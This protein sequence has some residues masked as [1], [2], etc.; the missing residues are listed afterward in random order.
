MEFLDTQHGEDFRILG[1]DFVQANVHHVATD[2]LDHAE[3]AWLRREKNS[4][5]GIGAKVRLRG[6][7]AVAANQEFLDELS[8][9]TTLEHLELG[10]PTTATDLSPLEKLTSL[11]VLKIDSPRN[12]TDFTPLTRLP[13]LRILVIENAKHMRSLDWLA[14]L[15]PQLRALSIEGTIDTRQKIDSIAPLAGFAFEA[16]S[17]AAVQ[18][19][20]KDLTPLAACP[21]LHRF[22]PARFAPKSS[23]DALKAL[24]PDIECAW[25]DRWEIG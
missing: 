18:I 22:S 16:L 19:V 9:L 23:F 6:L 17:L 14:P 13:K 2:I 3:F 4:H 21:N 7:V 15:G 5:R 25:F 12:I 11:T 10:Y 24:R 8:N 1:L 20:D